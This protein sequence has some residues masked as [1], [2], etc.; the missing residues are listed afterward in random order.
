MG[1]WFTAKKRS[2]YAQI[3][4][5]SRRRYSRDASGGEIGLSSKLDTK[6]EQN[7]KEEKHNTCYS[8]EE[9]TFSEACSASTPRHFRRP[10]NRSEIGHSNYKICG[11]TCFKFRC[12]WRCCCFSFFPPPPVTVGCFPVSHPLSPNAFPSSSHLPLFPKQHTH[13]LG[14]LHCTNTACHNRT[15]GWRGKNP[16]TPPV[17]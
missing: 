14:L 13:R 1:S 10:Q 16:T 5:F 12:L 7:R 6:V 2:N 17:K 15:E 11:K 3:S 4:I 8:S 9:K